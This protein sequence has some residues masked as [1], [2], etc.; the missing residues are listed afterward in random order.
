VLGD[1]QG[2]LVDI[3]SYTFDE[4]GNNIFGVAYKPHHLTGTGI[5]NDHPVRGIP[6]NVMVEF[7]TGYDVDADDYR[8]VKALCER[9]NIHLPREYEKFEKEG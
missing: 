6:P 1:D 2:H 9:F 8:D 5:I 7:H 3:H 4:N